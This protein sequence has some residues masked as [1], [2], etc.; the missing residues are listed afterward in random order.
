MTFKAIIPRIKTNPQKV[1]R[2]L[3]EGMDRY[4]KLVLKEFQETVQTWREKPSFTRLVT[5]SGN[6]IIGEVST[7]NK[8]YVFVSG[9]TKGHRVPKS[10]FANLRFRSQYTAKTSPGRIPSG[11]G[12]ASGN[13]VY[14][15]GH[16]VKG[17]KARKFDK[18]IMDDTEK[19]FKDYM[20]N[21]FENAILED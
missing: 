8:I 7:T 21:A 4:T 9:G 16:F 14:S 20:L 2:K 17:I 10:G 11:S 13:Y 5:T 15:R 19:R 6:K 18:Q 3:I 1:N 12:G